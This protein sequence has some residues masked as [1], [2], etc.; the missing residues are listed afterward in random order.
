VFLYEATARLMAGASP[1]KTQQLFDRS[2]RNRSTR[3][4]VICTKGKNLGQ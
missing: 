3:H 1:T 4:F 2:L